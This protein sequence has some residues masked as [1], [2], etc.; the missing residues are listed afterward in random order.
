MRSR[1]LI[2][3][4]TAEANDVLGN[5]LMRMIPLICQNV[6]THSADLIGKE[7]IT[8]FRSIAHRQN[9]CSPGY[10]KFGRL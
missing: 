9:K 10:A 2:I 7:S 4:V 6:E 8:R 3:H 5:D 1:W